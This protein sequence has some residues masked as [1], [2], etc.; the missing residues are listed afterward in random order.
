MRFV[1]FLYTLHSARFGH[2]THKGFWSRL[3][4]WDQGCCCSLS[5]TMAG[6]FRIFRVVTIAEHL[7]QKVI[8][9]LNTKAPACVKVS[10][11][12][13]SGVVWKVEC[14]Q[15]GRARGTLCQG[16]SKFQGAC[17]Q[18][19]CSSSSLIFPNILQG[20]CKLESFLGVISIQFLD[21]KL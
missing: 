4:V 5:E 21:R 18:L 1:L 15:R 10:Y 19:S 6:M 12:F 13:I 14:L 2:I 20:P 3:K 8:W 17:S 16:L 11:T 9:K 7:Q